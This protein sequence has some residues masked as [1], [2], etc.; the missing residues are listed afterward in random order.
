MST[1]GNQEKLQ[2]PE[3]E[4]RISPRTNIPKA[5]D[6]MKDIWDKYDNFIISGI[7]AGISRTLLFIEIFRIKFKDFYQYNSIETITI[8]MK[9]ENEQPK[10][11]NKKRYL[12]RF[13]VEIY[14]K[15][16][17]NPQGFYQ[18]PYTEEK[19][20]QLSEFKPDEKSGPRGGFRGRGF[21]G[22]GRGFRGTRGRGR[23]F[24][25][26]RGRGERGARGRG[27]RG[28]RGRGE[29]GTRGRGERGT[30]GRGERGTRGGLR[31]KPNDRPQNDNQN[32]NYVPGLGKGVKT[33]RK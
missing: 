12:T 5:I 24:R 21:R 14:K 7:N 28:A 30:R 2:A 10:E 23:A 29:R 8:E 20:K 22:R 6:R 11:D 9:E 19:V 31:G 4:F 18:Q 15:K 16:P 33:G 3:N 32:D 27:E 25:G 1:P 13:K 26:A 17:T